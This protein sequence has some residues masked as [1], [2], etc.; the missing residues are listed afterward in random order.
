MSIEVITI[1]LEQVDRILKYEESHFIDLKSIDIKPAKLSKSI[2]AFANVNGGELLIGI[3]EY[4]E[5]N[6]KVRRWEGLANQEAAN[7][8][9]QTFESL[10]PLGFGYSYTFLHSENHPGLVLQVTILKS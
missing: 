6:K 9:L 1:T 8:H 5:E 3:C 7:G 10:F 2:S 4:T